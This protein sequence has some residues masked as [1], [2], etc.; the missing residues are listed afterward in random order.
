MGL[1]FG[2]KGES[3]MG[4]YHGKWSFQTFSYDR[5]VLHRGYD[6][7]GNKTS[8]ETRYPPYN[9]FKYKFLSNVLR[10]FDYLYMDIFKYVPHFATFILGAVVMFSIMY[11]K[12]YE[13]LF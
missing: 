1:P 8:M 12:P 2:G 7:L 5:A 9:N 4:R 13:K 3:G 11:F 10:W 6:P